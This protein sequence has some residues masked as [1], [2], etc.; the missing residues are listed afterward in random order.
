MHFRA[1]FDPAAQALIL[2]KR[3]HHFTTTTEHDGDTQLRRPGL[4]EIQAAEEGGDAT[5]TISSY[6]AD[7]AT[8][9]AQNYSTAPITDSMAD[10][11]YAA[12]SD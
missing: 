11:T 10:A 12:Q 1:D 6:S 5:P 9:A 7:P 8:Y 4:R 3:G 2:T